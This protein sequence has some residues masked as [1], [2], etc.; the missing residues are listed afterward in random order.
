M[1]PVEK[2]WMNGKLVPWNEANV[3]VTTYTLHYGV[4]AFEGIRA[5]HLKDGRTGIFRLKEHMK[6]LYDSGKL[7][8][9]EPPYSLET[10]EAACV[11]TIKAN[12][13]KECY[14]RPLIWYGGGDL[15]VGVINDVNLAIIVWE[16]G[17]YLGEEGIKNGI[18]CKISSFQRPHPA[19]ALPKG[20][21]SGQYIMGFLAK[22]E[23]K[24]DGY[25]EAIM[26]DAS[27]FVSEG[28]G[29]NLFVV[30]DGTIYTPAYSS[31][32]LGGI[33]R[34][35][36]IQL[37]REMGLEVVETNISR[38]MLMLADEAFFSGTAAEVTPIRE[39][40]NRPIGTGKPGPITKE[41]QST[42]FKVVHGELDRYM[43][44]FTMVE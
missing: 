13:L 20:K 24:Q 27:G 38:E 37:A 7:V 10:A 41:L 42:Y 17:A 19:T 35:T 29:E 5:Y 11:E 4:A 31:P 43:N 23:A 40:D 2:I 28:T 32:I 15:G 6:R 22:W 34:A 8:L 9:M 1:K 16:W 44:W 25:H 30:I 21:L 3:H 39:I 14:I 33:T 36:V 26:L 18:R 12:G